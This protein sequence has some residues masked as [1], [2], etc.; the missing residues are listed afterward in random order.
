METDWKP[1]D[2]IEFC[3]NLYI[4]VENHGDSGVV[5][6][7]C[8]GGLVISHWQWDFAGAKCELVKSADSNKTA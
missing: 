1:G 2:V 8:E 6:E 7:N 3:E 5:R 4:V